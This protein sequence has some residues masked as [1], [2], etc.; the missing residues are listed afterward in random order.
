MLRYCYGKFASNLT[1]QARL[2]SGKNLTAQWTIPMASMETA[3]STKE[4]PK[5]NIQHDSKKQKFFVQFDSG[6]FVFILNC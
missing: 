1:G 6:T 2:L 3:A 4:S 5:F